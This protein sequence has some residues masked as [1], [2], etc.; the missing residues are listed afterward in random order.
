MFKDKKK[1][2]NEVLNKD[3][4]CL[5]WF[6]SSKH[7]VSLTPPFNVRP[8]SCTPSIKFFLTTFFTSSSAWCSKGVL[9]QVRWDKKTMFSEQ[10]PG[11]FKSI[12][13]RPAGWHTWK[14]FSSLSLR[15]PSLSWSDTLKIR[16]RA[17]TQSG[18]IWQH[19]K[20]WFLEQI[21]HLRVKEV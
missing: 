14:K 1:S 5:I 18:F 17:F 12:K 21:V 20:R 8:L 15:I 3:T 16:A 13:G 9:K 11:T 2:K 4:T 6:F 19:K 7:K 10:Q